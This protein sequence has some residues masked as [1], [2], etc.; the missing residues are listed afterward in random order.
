MK[1]RIF[2]AA[3]ILLL[4]A[5]YAKADDKIPYGNVGTPITTNTDLVATGPVSVAYF[6]GYSAA[7]LDTVS[8]WDVT[9]GAWAGYQFFPNQTATVGATQTLTGVSV[10]DVLEFELYNE[11][12]NTWL[13]SDPASD[14][15][16]PGISHAYVTPY[17]ANPLDSDYIAGIPAGIFVGM[18]DL[19]AGQGSDYDYNDDQ[20][21]VTGA[22]ITPEPSSLFL[23]GTGLLGLVVLGRR[24]L[25]A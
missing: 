1:G 24:T 10:G 8:V 7:D 3:A 15:G 14:P 9:K 11:T 21:V 19:G 2:A 25:L 17:S 23:L 16:D 12:T 6:Y 20:Y 18:E 22:A 5:G 4:L 13:T